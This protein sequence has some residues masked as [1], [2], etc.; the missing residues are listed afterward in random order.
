MWTVASILFI[1]WVLSIHFYFPVALTIALFGAILLS[2]VMA[3][4]PA[5]TQS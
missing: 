5:K 2:V 1:L 3:I 4:L